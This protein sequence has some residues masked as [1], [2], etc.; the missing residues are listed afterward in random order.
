[1]RTNGGH[2]IDS[3][4]ALKPHYLIL[5]GSEGCDPAA[6]V[7]RPTMLRHTFPVLLDGRMAPEEAGLWESSR[8]PLIFRYPRRR[9]LAEL[10]SAFTSSSQA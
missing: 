5:R 2:E 9:A 1:M 6:S 8:S 3:F 4:D 10:L 7:D